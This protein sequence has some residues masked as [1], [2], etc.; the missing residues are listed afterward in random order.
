MLLKF[1]DAC[2]FALLFYAFAGLAI[3]CVAGVDRD[4]T[5]EFFQ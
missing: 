2:A 1:D 5:L 4:E 3:F